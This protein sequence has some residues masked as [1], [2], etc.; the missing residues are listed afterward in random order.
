MKHTQSK[1]EKCF[2]DDDDNNNNY[3]MDSTIKHFLHGTRR[4]AGRNERGNS[5]SYVAT[6]LAY[7]AQT[8]LT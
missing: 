2:D 7:G 5:A 1:K 8:G 3:S 6:Q 4:Q